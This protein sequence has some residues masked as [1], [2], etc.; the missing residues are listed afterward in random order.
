[1][2]DTAAYGL[3]E[4]LWPDNLLPLTFLIGSL[5]DS[6][7]LLLFCLISQFMTQ[8]NQQ[9]KGGEGHL[10][11]NRRAWSE[12]SKCSRNASMLPCQDIM[13]KCVTKMHVCLMLRDFYFLRKRQW[14]FL[15]SSDVPQTFFI[16]LNYLMTSAS[17]MFLNILN[18]QSNNW[19]VSSSDATFSA[20]NS[21]P[22][23]SLVR[24]FPGRGRREGCLC[25]RVWRFIWSSA[26][27]NFWNIYFPIQERPF[28]IG[29]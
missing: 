9:C 13:P 4:E 22:L 17:F 29:S 14:H 8:S 21:H 12:T 6:L 19:R 16:K 11:H 15:S 18:P 1:M 26:L 3:L 5:W 23:A 25:L 2:C 24:F 10:R 7:P 28:E 27:W 20:E